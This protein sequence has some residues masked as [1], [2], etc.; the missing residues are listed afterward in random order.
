MFVHPRFEISAGNFHRHIPKRL[1][2]LHRPHDQRLQQG[3]R[4]RQCRRGRQRQRD[5]I[6]AHSAGKGL[7]HQ[8]D[9]IHRAVHPHRL[10]AI[11]PCAVCFHHGP[12]FLACQRRFHQGVRR[13]GHGVQGCG[14][15]QPAGMV[16]KICANIR[17]SQ[18]FGHVI[19][20]RLV[21]GNIFRRRFRQRTRLRRQGIRRAVAAPIRLENAVCQR[22]HRRRSQ[23]HNSRHDGGA[24]AERVSLGHALT[25]KR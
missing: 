3:I 24:P 20:G 2:R 18:N 19:P 5:P 21:P 7:A 15:L 22:H 1:H 16:G 4:R 23:R 12:G 25:S 8:Q 11:Q 6:C 14:C 17:R 13:L 10:R 9:A